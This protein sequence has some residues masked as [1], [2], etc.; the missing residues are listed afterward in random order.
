MSQYHNSASLGVDIETGGHV[1]QVFVTNSFG[2]QETQTIAN[3]TNSWAK[4]QLILGFNISR[5]FTL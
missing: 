3:T 5:Y 4:G 2:I 1:F